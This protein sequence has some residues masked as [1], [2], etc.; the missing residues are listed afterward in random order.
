ML[1]ELY[2]KQHIPHKDIAVAKNSF[3]THLKLLLYINAELLCVF[4][5]ER[6]FSCSSALGDAESLISHYVIQLFRCLYLLNSDD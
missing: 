2:R 4:T 6:I 3:F 1:M 5:K